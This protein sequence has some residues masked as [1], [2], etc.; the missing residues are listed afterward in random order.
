LFQELPP[1][2]VHGPW[3]S[4]EDF[5]RFHYLALREDA[6]HALRNSVAGFRTHP[7]MKEDK[8]TY[9][10]SKVHFTGLILA[11]TG[12]GFRVTFSTERSGMNIRWEQS[13]RLQQGTLVAISTERDMFTN[14]CKV[15][16]V[17]GQYISV[18][19]VIFHHANLNVARPLEG[20]LDQDPPTVD[21][22]WGD[23]NRAV[24]DPAEGEY[25]RVI[26]VI[27]LANTLAAYI[28]IEARSGYFEA[29]RHVLL[30][31]QDVAME[32]FSLKKHIIGLDNDIRAPAYLQENPFIDVTSLCSNVGP[33]ELDSL[34]NF[35]VLDDP[36][37]Q[38]PNSSMDSSQRSA[39]QRIV[40][41]YIKYDYI[42]RLITSRLPNLWL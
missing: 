22:F 28:M 38:L 35:N 15:A 5:L 13:K 4:T 29:Y 26:A 1:N 30:G 36:L 14:I 42:Q 40:S 31:I 16:V 12:V 25:E 17:A 19:K 11:M 8:E 3:P 27:S 37:P 20:G 23:E 39:F 6:I 7:G 21:L 9:I 24:L 18:R 32:K 33:D 10:Y 41:A 2:H 34:Q